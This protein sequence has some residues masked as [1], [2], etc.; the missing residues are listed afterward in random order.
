LVT[1]EVVV[2]SVAVTEVD[3]V[4]EEVASVAVIVEVVEV[5][6]V[7]TVEASVEEEEVVEDPEV[8]YSLMITIKLPKKVPLLVMLVQK[9]SF[10]HL[11]I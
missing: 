7:V 3:L 1:V 4:A 10:E 8:E 6:V 5:S 11:F 9:L 2:V